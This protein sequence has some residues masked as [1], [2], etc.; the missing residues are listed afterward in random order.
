MICFWLVLHT[1]DNKNTNNADLSPHYIV[2]Q[3]VILR[4]AGYQQ[5]DLQLYS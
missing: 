4:Y 2:L 5:K 1:K 3:E